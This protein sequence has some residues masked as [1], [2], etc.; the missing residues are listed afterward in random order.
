MVKCARCNNNPPQQK[1]D[2]YIRCRSN[3]EWESNFD[4]CLRCFLEIIKG[5]DMKWSIRHK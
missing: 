2:F 1:P 3:D 4:V 5:D